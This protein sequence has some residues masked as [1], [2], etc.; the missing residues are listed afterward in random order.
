[1][2]I[3]LIR[4]TKPDIA[5]GICYGQ[6]DL[7]VADTFIEEAKKIGN[8]LHGEFDRFY[9]SP[10]I[11]C[12]QLAEILEQGTPVIEPRLKEMN[13]GQWE[14]QSW[15]KIPKSELCP[16]MKDFVNRRVP[17]GESMAQLVSR[18]KAWY[19]EL[20]STGAIRVLVVTHAGPIRVILSLINGTPIEDAFKL[21]KPHFGEVISLDRPTEKGR[22]FR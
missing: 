8:S 6:S 5:E 3:Y 14:M 21:Y 10:L 19:G 4:H 13:F 22:L 12:H 16:W 7:H 2:E 9:S 15:D 18:V 17:D 20:L 11:R 1:M